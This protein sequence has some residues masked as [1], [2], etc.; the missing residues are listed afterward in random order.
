[1]RR[2]FPKSVRRDTF[3]RAKGCCQD[4]GIKIIAGNG[5][6]YDHAVPD[7]LGGEPTLDN[8]VVRCT[9]CHRLKTSTRDVP[10]IA[11]MKRQRD[12]A[13]GIKRTSQTFPGGK[14]SRF[15]R[16]IDGTVID[17]FTGQEV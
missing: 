12:R 1:M 9:K 5:P 17:R 8:C 13:I 14:Q 7:A 16:R 15:K 3:T 6:E 11:K 10:Q 4:C 2:E